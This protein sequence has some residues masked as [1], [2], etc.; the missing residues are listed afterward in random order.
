[1]AK[2]DYYLVDGTW[3]YDTDE[4]KDKKDYVLKTTHY[5]ISGTTYPTDAEIEA[6]VIAK[7]K[8]VLA[9][10]PVATSYPLLQDVIDEGPCHYKYNKWGGRYFCYDSSGL[11]EDYTTLATYVSS[12][13][14]YGN[15]GGKSLILDIAINRVLLEVEITNSSHSRGNVS[16]AYKT[17]NIKKC[18]IGT[19]Y[20]DYKTASTQIDFKFGY[21]N[22]SRNNENDPMRYCLENINGFRCMQKVFWSSTN[23]V[24]SKGLS[25][26][27]YGYNTDANINGNTSNTVSPGNCIF[28]NNEPLD[29][30]APTEGYFVVNDNYLGYY[31]RSNAELYFNL[32]TDEQ[33]LLM[34]ATMGF[35]FKYNGKIYKPVVSGGIVTG[36]TD[37]LDSKSE[38]DDWKN[39]GDHAFPVNP[40]TPLPPKEGFTPNE[41]RIAGDVNG[42]G[43]FYLMSGT[44]LDSL[45]DAIKSAPL[46]FD[47]RN[48]LISCYAIPNDG[49][50][51]DA[52][53]PSTIKFRLGGVGVEKIEVWDTEVS[54]N[55]ISGSAQ[56]KILGRVFI[57]RPT[58]T[59]L[60]FEPYTTLELY[61]PFCGWCSLPPSLC[62][63]KEIVVKLYTNVPLCSC[64]VVVEVGGCAVAHMQGV[65]GSMVPFT[66]DGSAIKNAEVTKNVIDVLGSAVV[67]VAGA[68]TGSEM[69]IAAGITG[70]IGSASQAAINSRKNYGYYV[71]GSGDSTTFNMGNRCWYKLVY[72]VPDIPSTYGHVVGYICNKTMTITNGMGFTIIDDPRIN[73]NCTDVERD[74]LR[75]LLLKGVIF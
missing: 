75:E 6:T 17:P 70:A 47:L 31:D 45:S 43:R 48:S 49:G 38:W 64:R 30:D 73:V 33:C 42:L 59:F 2:Y 34:V 35:A 16:H 74:E 39:I 8:N 26:I 69:A 71:G 7:S 36:Y 51:V 10:C 50:L 19:N 55:R 63:G 27:K 57:P 40:D 18:F 44:Q 68:A 61:V 9:G 23:L 5:T 24:Q 46:G 52:P 15:L 53:V 1:M 11:S 66:S 56:G 12:V 25:S 29:D 14:M 32:V 60:D 37:D 65:W 28:N 54:A 20:Q 13:G 72:P 22:K 21:L 41:Y 58:D 4:E 3:V 62:V 67:G